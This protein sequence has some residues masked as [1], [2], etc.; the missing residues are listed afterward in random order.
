MKF[1]T[2]TLLTLATTYTIAVL[3]SANAFGAAGDLYESDLTS[4][5]IFKFTPDGTKTVFASGLTQ[6]NGIAFDRAGNLFVSSR[7]GGTITKITLSATQT[8]VASGLNFPAGLAFDASGTLYVAEFGASQIVQITPAG[9]KSTYAS[10]VVNP[11]CLAFDHAGNLFVSEQGNANIISKFGTGKTKTTFASNVDS[12]SGLVFDSAG[13]LYVSTYTA[14]GGTTGK[15]LKFAPDGSRTTYASALNAPYGMA[16]DRMAFLFV[17]ERGT[18]SILEF[19]YGNKSTFASSLSL[20][21]FLAIEPPLSQPVNI[22][23]RLNVQ[24]GDNVLIAGFIAT[25]TAPK[26]LVIRALGPS[27]SQFGIP[28]A[29]MDPTL[30]LHAANGSLIASNDSWKINDETHQSQQAAIQA[31]GLAPTDDREC[32]LTAELAPAQFTVVVRGKNNTTGVATVEVYDANQA[33]DSRLSNISTRGVV[34]DGANVMI[35]GFVVGSG[36][37]AA[38]VLLRAL[39]PSLANFGLTGVLDDPDMSLRDSNGTEIAYCSY[40]YLIAGGDD[41]YVKEIQATG[42]APSEYREAAILT[43]LPNGSY[44]AIVSGHQGETGIGLVEVYDLN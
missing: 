14:L 32:V 33:V 3:L 2:K 18:N 12:P 25:G 16:L 17:A 40:W 9:T 31:T 34:G 24:T 1:T 19:K 10:N 42:L 15:I 23:T 5:T 35:G 37:G 44:T 26:K 36:N 29:L 4:G 7:S 11:A 41:S 28:T 30:E 8:P 27:L 38:K 13:N 39:G 20:P 43:T 21:Q 22:S 6:P